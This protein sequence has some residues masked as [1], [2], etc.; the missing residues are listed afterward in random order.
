VDLEAI[1]EAC[2][3]SIPDL[4]LEHERLESAVANRLIAAGELG[5]VADTRGLEPDEIV[6]VMRNRLRVGLGEADAD[7]DREPKALHAG[8]LRA[9]TSQSS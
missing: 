1:V 8:T 7:L 9:W 4:S 3:L 5:E 6:G 2:R